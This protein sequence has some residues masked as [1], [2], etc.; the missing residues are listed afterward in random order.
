M[1]IN[2]KKIKEKLR[3]RM[4]Q[5][6]PEQGAGKTSFYHLHQLPFSADQHSGIGVIPAPGN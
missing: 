6:I 1:R 2:L 5:P 3:R 4:H